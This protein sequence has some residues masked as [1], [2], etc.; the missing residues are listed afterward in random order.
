MK[1]YVITLVYLLFP[2]LIAYAFHRY[3]FLQKVGTVIMAYAV[4][5]IMALTGVMTFE[6]ADMA[7][8]S[9]TMKT[10]QT[11]RL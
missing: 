1:V 8:Q 4:G 11:L 9:Q 5:V 3:K 2:F 10:I 7:V 6:G